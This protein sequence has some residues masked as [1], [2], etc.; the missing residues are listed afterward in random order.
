MQKSTRS[1]TSMVKEFTRQYLLIS[2]FPVVVFFAFAIAGGFI[3]QRHL[4]ALIADSTHELTSDAK[5]ELE[6]LGQQVIQDKA[7]DAARQV[8]LFLSLKP[9]MGIDELQRSA[10]FQAI[11]MQPVGKNGYVCLYEAG[12]GIMRIH[13]NPNLA[14]RKMDFLSTEIPSWWAIFARSLPGKEIS[15]Y[16]DWIEPDGSVRKKYMAMTP[17]EAPLQGKT[18]MVAATTYIDEFSAPVAAMV[19]KET[20]I[21][22]DFDDFLVDQLLIAGTLVAVF[23]SVTFLSVYLIGRRSALGYMLP[24]VTMAAAAENFGDGH[25]DADVE[26]SLI[27]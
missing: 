27:D 10:K 1:S 26:P 11:A 20:A 25:W 2:L 9:E 6:A 22:A 17:V 8:A 21:S 24:I 15:G 5:K 12:T 14:N 3:A 19:Q 13:P 4:S 16:Y 23:L 7:R 18:L